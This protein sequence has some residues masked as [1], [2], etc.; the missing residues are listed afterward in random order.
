MLTNITNTIIAITADSK[1]GHEDAGRGELCVE[2]RKRKIYFNAL[3]ES[4]RVAGGRGRAREGALKLCIFSHRLCAERAEPFA[5]GLAL[6]VVLDGRR[7]RRTRARAGLRRPHGIRLWRPHGIRLWR[8]LGFRLRRPHGFH[9][10]RPRG[11]LDMLNGNECHE[12][13]GRGELC[14][15]RRKRKIYFNALGESMRVAGRR[16]ET[17][18][19]F[20]TFTTMLSPSQS[21]EALMRMLDEVSLRSRVDEK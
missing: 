13:A 17:L 12:D 9:L 5:E 20:L 10:R 21:L 6:G 11:A 2:S 7:P 8:P 1:N 3:G 19:L 4:G 16:V 14:V 18:Y 15:E